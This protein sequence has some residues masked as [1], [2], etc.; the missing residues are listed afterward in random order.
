MDKFTIILT[1]CD[2]GGFSAS[3]KE[4]PGAISEG[5]TMMEASENVFDA[6]VQLLSAQAHE[7]LANK[8]PEDS[9]EVE[10]ALA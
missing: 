9:L 10:L 7:Q 4:V 8:S 1:R 3:I 2:E 6:L 5:E